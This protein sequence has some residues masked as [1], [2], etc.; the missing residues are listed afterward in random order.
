MG[1]A[2]QIVDRYWAA[3]E[4]GDFGRVADLLTPESEMGGAGFSAKGPDQ[5]VGLLRAYKTAFPD[6]R[7]VETSYVESGDAIAIE[8]RVTGTMRGPLASPRGDIPPTGKRL[9]LPSA[10]HVTVKDGKIRTWHS[11]F[12]NA[13][14]MGQLGLREP[15][16]A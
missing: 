16:A 7:H 8:L 12:D 15:A 6:L 4:T 10:D 5:I 2:R 9:D 14:F 11:Y 3:F 1:Q 13:A